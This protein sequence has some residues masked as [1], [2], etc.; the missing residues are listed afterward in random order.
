MNEINITKIKLNKKNSKYIFFNLCRF[1]LTTYI[2]I[3]TF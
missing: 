1:S 3:H 2:Q